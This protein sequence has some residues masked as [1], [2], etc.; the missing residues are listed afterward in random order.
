MKIESSGEGRQIDTIE[1]K[2][3]KLED[4]LSVRMTEMLGIHDEDPLGTL[5]TMSEEDL[6][7]FLGDAFTAI[8]LDILKD[9]IRRKRE[10]EVES[11]H[12]V[13]K[14]V[15]DNEYYH[16]VLY[17]IDGNSYHHVDIAAR[18]NEGS[19]IKIYLPELGEFKVYFPPIP[20]SNEDTIE[21]IDY[22]AECVKD[23]VVAVP[24]TNMSYYQYK[25]REDI[26][27]FVD[28]MF[29]KFMQGRKT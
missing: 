13:E 29:G 24:E 12:T 27:Q 20:D 15:W 3:L 19:D 10:A 25:L 8:E 7:L 26:K 17:K 16:R 18:F 9:R 14:I 11:G 1:R 6:P 23:M 4:K 21:F 22:L 2:P 28:E 5:T